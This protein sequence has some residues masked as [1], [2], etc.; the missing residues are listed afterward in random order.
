MSGLPPTVKRTLVTCSNTTC[1]RHGDPSN[2]AP[3]KCANCKSARYCDK[4]CQRQH[5]SLHKE[6]CKVWAETSANNGQLP[7]AQIKLKMT[8]LIWL[9]RGMPDFCVYMFKEYGYWKRQGKRGCME[10]EFDRWEDL[11]EAI[12]LVEGFPTY[13]EMPF[14]AMP[15][16]PSSTL[17]GGRQLTLPLRRA[18]Q[19]ELFKFAQVIDDRL[20]FT[21]NENRPNLQRALD[22]AMHSD[23]LFV[24]S[25][26]VKLEGTYSTHIYDFFYRTISWQP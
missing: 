5:W 11:F 13:G 10:F 21:E 2:K 24:I 26:T 20:H 15:G 12:R 17:P 8:H 4:T 16:T 19:E 6:F 22:I 14:V 3:L 18:P 9:L 1:P 25:I 23:N 7:V